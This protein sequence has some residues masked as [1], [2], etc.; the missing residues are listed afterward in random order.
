MG[1]ENFTHM[2]VVA[3]NGVTNC[4]FHVYFSR[5]VRLHVYIVCGRSGMIS[6]IC[7]LMFCIK[8]SNYFFFQCVRYGYG[9]GDNLYHRL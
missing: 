4:E 3:A 6:C 5:L 2:A 8:F 1:K 7:F 9:S